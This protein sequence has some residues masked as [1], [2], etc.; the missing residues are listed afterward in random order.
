MFVIDVFLLHKT[1]AFETEDLLMLCP[2]CDTRIDVW[3]H[4]QFLLNS[5]NLVFIS[6]LPVSILMPTCSDCSF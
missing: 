2:P 5:T 3:L 4:G 6:S 1:L